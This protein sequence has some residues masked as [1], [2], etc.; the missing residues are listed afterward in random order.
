[1][2]PFTKNQLND[3]TFKPLKIYRNRRKDN[4]KITGRPLWYWWYFTGYDQDEYD[5]LTKDH[6]GR[7]SWKP[8]L[9]KGVEIRIVSRQKSH[10][11]A[12]DQ[13][14]KKT[15]ARW[16]QYVNAF[17]EGALPYPPHVEEVLKIFHDKQVRQAVVS[18]KLKKQYRLDFVSKGLD[19][20]MET[21]VLG[22][23]TDRPKPDPA[24]ID[25]LQLFD[26]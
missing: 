12:F 9:W 8:T 16:F 4:E 2:V 10:G 6:S 13:K 5:S 22:E 11:R 20:Y 17:E 1:M 15:Y 21:A 26:E 25:L 18:S 7:T 14:S 23:D 3:P 19:Q 24:P